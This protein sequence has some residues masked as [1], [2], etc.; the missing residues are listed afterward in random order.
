MAFARRRRP[1]IPAEVTSNPDVLGGAPCVS[2]TRIPALNIV[3]ALRDGASLGD[4]QLD[5]PSL[6]VDGIEAVKAW[7]HQEGISL[8]PDAPPFETIEWPPSSLS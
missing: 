7:A 2:G 8:S 5:Y 3:A 4:L 1:L 6:P